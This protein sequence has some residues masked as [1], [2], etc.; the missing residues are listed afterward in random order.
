MR[1]IR[2]TPNEGG[3]YPAIQ[4]VSPSGCS[5]A[6]SSAYSSPVSLSAA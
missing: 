1:V 6:V 3:A 5:R 4:G 2:I